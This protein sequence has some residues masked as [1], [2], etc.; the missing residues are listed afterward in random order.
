MGKTQI[1]LEL[2]YQMRNTHPDCSIF[3][4]PAT[5]IERLHQAYL[6]IGRQLRMPGVDDQQADI[7]KLVQLHLSQENTN[8]WL[9]IFDNA[10]D[11]DMWIKKPGYTIGSSQRLTDCLPSHSR[12]SIVFTTS[13][14]KIAVKLAQ[15]NVI[16]FIEMNEDVATQLL[17][18]SLINK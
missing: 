10:D 14:L 6:E 18:K 1:V 7:K 4:I 15:Q 2:A 11:M 17:S 5:N 3:W 8:Q 13:S 12:G 16:K 9:L